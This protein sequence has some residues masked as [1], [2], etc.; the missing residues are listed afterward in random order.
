[1]N[2]NLPVKNDTPTL[3]T[4]LIVGKH[5]LV[6]RLI[7]QPMEGCDGNMDGT[8]DELTFR[9]YRRFAESGVGLIWLEA[10]SVIREGRSNPRQL[11]IRKENVGV[12]ARLVSEM[13]EIALR[14]TGVLP[15]IIMQSTHSGRY[16]RT[17]GRPEPLIAHNNPQF[18]GRHSLPPECVIADDAL[19]RL[20]ERFAEAARLA[21]Q[22]GFDGVDVKA[23]H[24]YLNNELLGAHTRPGAYGGSFENRTRFFR[25]VVEAIRANVPVNFIVTSRMNVYDGFAYPYGFGVAR[26]SGVE[27][28]LSEPIQLL[29]TLGFDMV[30]VTMGN[31]Y[32]NPSVSRP[33]DR[34]AVDRMRRLTQE[35]QAAYPQMAVVASGVSYLRGRSGEMAERYVQ[36]GVCKLVGFGRMAFAYPHF[37]RDILSGDFNNRQTCTTCGKCSQLMRADSVTGCVVRDEVYTKLFKEITEK[38]KE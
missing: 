24:G 26:D 30:N 6:N 14:D 11:I 15:V 33:T 28:D 17:N 22:A 18:E 27:P 5:I 32:Q 34:E 7:I 1:M 12:F 9:R 38:R 36:S 19:K 37:A 20:E 31:P 4:P 21:L 8:P 35:I 16:C 29:K 23:C 13:R 3:Q 25:N 2:G 10:V